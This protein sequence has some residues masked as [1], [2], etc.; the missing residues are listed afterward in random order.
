ME[1]SG[2]EALT[3][4]LLLVVPGVI[5]A[6]VYDLLIPGDKR[7]WSDQLA[8]A[9]AYGFFNFIVW[10]WLIYDSIELSHSNR[11][12]ATIGLAATLLVSPAL[13]GLLAFKVRSGKWLARWVRTPTPTAW[14]HVFGQTKEQRRE[15]WVRI[16]LND[17]RMLG[18]LLSK[19]SYAST[20]P[21]RQDLFVQEEW[22]LDNTGRFVEKLSDT[23]G[24]L[25]NMDNCRLIEFMELEHE[26]TR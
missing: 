25:V 10:W 21:Q 17:G 19:G 16:H 1:L 11:V 13:L 18:G 22:R 8:E 6:I 7:N 5:A 9:V 14:D 15:R 26:V 12:Q 2:L 20:Y 3:A 24:F 4:L 23:G